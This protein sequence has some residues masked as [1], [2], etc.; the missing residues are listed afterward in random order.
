MCCLASVT[1]SLVICTKSLGNTQKKQQI[2]DILKGLYSVWR[3]SSDVLKIL[4]LLL[5]DVL[6]PNI[7]IT[8]LKLLLRRKLIHTVA[9]TGKSPPHSAGAFVWEAKGKTNKQIYCSEFDTSEGRGGG[10]I[11]AVTS[12]HS[13]NIQIT[14]A[15]PEVKQERERR[16]LNFPKGTSPGLIEVSMYQIKRIKQNSLIR[17]HFLFQV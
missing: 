8:S 5:L 2:K 6:N 10:F 4:L 16:L 11:W 9:Q 15:V 17:G 13:W 7:I 12:I 1:H 14:F 3:T